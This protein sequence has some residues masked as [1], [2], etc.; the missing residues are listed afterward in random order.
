MNAPNGISNVSGGRTAHARRLS[1]FI[2][3]LAKPTLVL[4]LGDNVTGTLRLVDRAAYVKSCVADGRPTV[5][6]KGTQQC[7]RVLLCHHFF[8]GS[9]LK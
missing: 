8:P 4:G 3:P 5:M 6:A 9:R 7:V 1:L 2:H